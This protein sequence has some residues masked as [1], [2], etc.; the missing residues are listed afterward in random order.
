[1]LN[2]DSAMAFK[3]RLIPGQG[4]LSGDQPDAWLAVSNEPWLQ[5]D[6]VAPRLAGYFVRI[7]YDSSLLDAPTRPILR[8]WTPSGKVET[9]L[10]APILG[11]GIWI[12]K[13]A[14]ETTKLEISP[15]STVGPFGFRIAALRRL[16]RISVWVRLLIRRPGMALL[17]LGAWMRRNIPLAK[18]RLERGLLSTPLS[19]YT[20]WARDRRR[21][22]DWRG[23]D[24]PRSVKQPAL[25]ALVVDGLGDKTSCSALEIDAQRIEGRV[26]LRDAIDDF[27]DDDIVFI[28]REK[29]R[30]A[31]YTAR[32]ILEAQTRSQAD[33]L[34]VD[35]EDLHGGVPRLKPGWSPTLAKSVDLFGPIWFARVGWAK[36]RFGCTP[37]ALLPVP[38]PIAGDNVLHLAR[39][40]VACA[41]RSA[42]KSQLVAT[43][44]GP[45]QSCTLIIPTRDRV[46]LLSRCIHSLQTWLPEK[47]FDAI[48]VDNGSVEPET[49]E[50]FQHLR[51]DM[52]FRIIKIPTP[53]NFSILCNAAAREAKAGTLVFLN[54]DIECRDSSW[55]DLMLGWAEQPDIGAVG[56]KL[57]YP[58]GTVQ[59]AG[60]GIGIFGRAGHFERGGEPLREGYFGRLGVPH[61]VSAVTG[62]CLAIEK[63]KFDSIGGF[64]EIN[65]PID[66]N[67]VDLCLRLNER[68]WR[69]LIEPRAILIHHESASRGKAQPAAERYPAESAWFR[70]RW[71][72]EIRND[73]YLN[74]GLS[75]FN[76]E[77]ALG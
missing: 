29:V 35:E 20:N 70:A 4:A 74:P 69:T 13:I 33:L 36:K 57:L 51:H 56:A 72:A 1:M 60:I 62:A 17:A 53:F 11:R 42:S 23:V 12:G 43:P 27:D 68:N 22:P 52:R 39:P 25:R 10:P 32:V 2:S 61:E 77:A 45:R 50:F 14:P 54:N 76:T 64:D 28:I 44:D 66:L 41:E 38:Q 15:S 48:I 6:V 24:F 5:I 71:R 26:P 55:L 9:I 49:K 67:D 63:S 21:L 37:V 16:S 73:L 3:P 47:R 40:L 65:L 30:L 31:P 7:A 8:A 34:Y 46:D 18:M 75:L 19:R 58:D 59:H